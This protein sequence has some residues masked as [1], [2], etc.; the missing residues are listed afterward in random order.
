MLTG[1][2]GLRVRPVW[3]CGQRRPNAGRPDRIRGILV[4]LRRGGG[5]EVAR[6]SES[7]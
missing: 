2:T 6:S 5:H 7:P 3:T 4:T 1:G